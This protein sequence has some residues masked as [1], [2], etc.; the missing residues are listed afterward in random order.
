MIVTNRTVLKWWL[1]RRD[2]MPGNATLEARKGISRSVISYLLT[3]LLVAPMMASAASY[4]EIRVTSGGSITG[5][6]T[7]EGTLPDDAV[8]QV[9]INKN[10]E[11]CG[12]GYREVVWIDV[13]DG[14]LRGSFVYLHKIKK[15]KAWSIPEGDNYMIV[16]KGCRF[17]PWAQVVKPGPIHI[18][19]KDKGVQHNINMVEMIGVEKRRVVERPM[20]NRNQPEPSTAIEEVKTVRAPHIALNCEVHNFMF[21]FMMAPKHPYAVVVAEDGSYSLDD[22]PPGKYTVKAWHPRLGV[23]KSKLTVTENG[24]V[25][26][27][28]VFSK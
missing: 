16:Q 18:V 21:G 10:P 22:I 23:K 27:N 28:F 4:Q 9:A 6:I 15:G 25:V 2:C 11:V 3:F 14:A 1:T 7:F 26:A 17:R 5:K 8:E 13:K 19:H 12:E 20:I 24:K